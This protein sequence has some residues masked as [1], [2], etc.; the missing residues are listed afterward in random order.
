MMNDVWTLLGI[1]ATDEVRAI[2]RAY[3]KRLKETRPADDPEG[4]QQ[5]RWA[6]E[7]AR[8]AAENAEPAYESVAE[9]AFPSRA[10]LDHAPS[11]STFVLQDPPLQHEPE[12]ALEDQEFAFDGRVEL[13]ARDST[14][15][16]DLE[17]D[18]PETHWDGS[19]DYEPE[20]TAKDHKPETDIDAWIEHVM[21]AGNGP[22]AFREATISSDLLPIR[23]AREFE[24]ALAFCFE[25]GTSDPARDFPLFAEIANY[26]R[27]DDSRHHV[28]DYF[29]E[30]EEPAIAAVGAYRCR[31]MA[32]GVAS[33]EIEEERKFK[34]AAQCLVGARSITFG[35][36][37]PILEWIPT[38]RGKYGEGWYLLLP[39]DV[40]ELD[41]RADRLE[42]LREKIDGDSV[43]W[44]VWF[45]G[46]VTGTIG[47]MVLMA[48]FRYVYYWVKTGWL[49]RKTM[50]ESDI[51]LAT[52][53]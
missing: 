9:H 5:L 28:L 31:E 42:H 10:R 4:F 30:L 22:L 24:L 16:D 7:T 13:D 18:L 20:E 49:R 2:K 21:T 19:S 50:P 6:Y 39:V 36:S 23:V 38:L 53:L 3:A 48:F 26:Y 12:P 27:W 40:T 1:E 44:G 37:K 15:S 11:L 43:H 52:E 14:D 51:D 29:P 33:G 35:R 25:Q 45:L 8:Q 47:F 17:W 46:V 32:Y 34:K 41:Y